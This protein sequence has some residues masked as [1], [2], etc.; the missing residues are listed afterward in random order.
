M[1]RLSFNQLTQ[2]SL[3]DTMAMPDINIRIS[4]ICKAQQTAQLLHCC[5]HCQQQRCRPLLT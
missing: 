3:F 1:R 5:A 4:S 2:A